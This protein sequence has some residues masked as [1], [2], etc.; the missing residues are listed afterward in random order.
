METGLKSREFSRCTAV[1]ADVDSYEV[2]DCP[3]PVLCLRLVADSVAVPS[4][5]LD[6]GVPLSSGPLVVRFQPPTR[7]MSWDTATLC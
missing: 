1:D 7:H 2:V 4:R 5:P 6:V 3:S